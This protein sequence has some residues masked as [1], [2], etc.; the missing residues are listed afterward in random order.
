MQI[1]WFN[2]DKLKNYGTNWKYFFTWAES[3]VAYNLVKKRDP[4]CQLFIGKLEDCKLPEMI[5]QMY[6][7][8]SDG[9]KKHEYEFLK[10]YYEMQNA[11]ADAM[12]GVTL[13]DETKA[14]YAEKLEQENLRAYVID[15]LQESKTYV[16][17]IQTNQA[18][19]SKVLNIETKMLQ[20]KIE[21]D[22]PN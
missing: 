5:K 2:L 6:K 11:H 22:L 17:T 12:N 16:Q 21:S 4:C 19:L 15:L 14:R 10:L 9:F 18:A 8:E 7:L 3:V 1:E 13:K 20:K